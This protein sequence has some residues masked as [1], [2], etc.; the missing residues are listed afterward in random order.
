MRRMALAEIEAER[1]RRTRKE[2]GE[3]AKAAGYKL[4]AEKK[5]RESLRSFRQA[6]ELLGEDTSIKVGIE[7]AEAEVKAEELLAKVQ[8]ELTQATSQ[9]QSG[10]LDGPTPGI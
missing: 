4:L 6:A 5:Y 9:F 10:D 2:E 1:I 3:R 8:T 7:E